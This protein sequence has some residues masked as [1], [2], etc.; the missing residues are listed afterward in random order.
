MAGFDG[1]A[2]SRGMLDLVSPLNKYGTVVV[3]TWTDINSVLKDIRKLPLDEK[4]VIIGY[5]GGGSRATWVS[6]YCYPRTIDLL[7]TYDPSPWSSMLPL[8][9]NVKKAINY[10]NE[11]PMMLGLGGGWLSGQQVDTVHIAQQHLAVQYNTQLHN[12]TISEVSKL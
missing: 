3:K 8:R 4:I 10:H 1:W 9:D 12:R 11:S 5:S 7:V 6:R 2:T